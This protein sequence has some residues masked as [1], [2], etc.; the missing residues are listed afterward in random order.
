MKGEHPG[1]YCA[2]RKHASLLFIIPSSRRLRILTLRT[3]LFY[4]AH[5]LGKVKISVPRSTTELSGP[6]CFL[7][8]NTAVSTKV[9]PQ[10]RK[11]V[12]D[13]ADWYNG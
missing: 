8:M 13:N 11:S 1:F 7:E 10:K 4:G 9:V 12:R 6:A 5:I 3:L 2:A